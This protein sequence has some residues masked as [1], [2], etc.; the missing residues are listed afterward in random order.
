MPLY[1]VDMPGYGYAEAPKTM[2][3]AWTRL[4]RDYLAGRTTLVRLFLLID[5]R[6]GIKANDEDIM[7]LLD[8][9]A[10]SYQVV[11]TKAD[12]LKAREVEAVLAD[13]TAKIA[14]RA[15]AFPR[16]VVTSSETGLGMA[17]LRA[18]IAE[19]AGRG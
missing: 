2:V 11:L 5:A 6:H 3:E 10:V 4:V 15:A 7:A 9:A 12:K 16:L 18:E 19:I 13:T 14:R 1:L 17:D 8:T